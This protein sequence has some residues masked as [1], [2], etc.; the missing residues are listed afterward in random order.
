MID[1][2]FTVATVSSPEAKEE[3]SSAADSSKTKP[4]ERRKR[5]ECERLQA[6]ALRFWPP[7]TEEKVD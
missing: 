7:K 5:Q 1:S 4:I 6:E 2:S 3:N